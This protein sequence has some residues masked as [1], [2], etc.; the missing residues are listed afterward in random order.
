M[1]SPPSGTFHL[2]TKLTKVM[3][4]LQKHNKEGPLRKDM[5]RSQKPKK[6]RMSASALG[7]KMFQAIREGDVDALKEL[8]EEQPA[9]LND[10]KTEEGDFALHVATRL[11]NT[12]IVE[13]LMEHGASANIQ[14]DGGQTP[15]HIAVSNED[16]AMVNF[17]ISRSA[18][19]DIADSELLTATDLASRLE[20]TEISEK[21]RERV[22][23]PITPNTP[24]TPRQ[25]RALSNVYDSVLLAITTGN[26][27][28]LKEFLDDGYLDE[29]LL[30]TKSENG[31]TPLHIAIK[32][33]SVEICKILVQGGAKTE[34]KAVRDGSTLLHQ[35]CM[36]GQLDAS[37]A[38]IKKGVLVHMPNKSGSLCIHEAAKKGHLGLVRMLIER[39]VPVNFQNKRKY[40]PLHLAALSKKHQVVQLLIGHGAEVTAIGGLAKETPLH[41]AAKVKGGEKVVDVLIKSG[42]DPDT[43]KDNGERALHLAARCGNLEVVNILLRENTEVARR[44]K[45]GDTPLHF[46]CQNGHF[47]IVE[48]L[49]KQLFKDKT[50]LL[51]RLIV[52]I[53][54]NLGV[55]ALHSVAGIPQGTAGTE[56]LVNTV[57]ILLNHGADL[58][59]STYQK[60]ETP[61]HWCARSGNYQM[62]E[63]IF[64]FPKV[65]EYI[66]L[67]IINKTTA[68]GASPLMIASQ[69]GMLEVVQALLRFHARV[70]VFDEAG[71]TALHYA[72]SRGHVEVARE[73]LNS[74][75]YVNG[76]TKPNVRYSS[77]KTRKDN[78]E[79]LPIGTTPL[80]MAAEMG[81]PEF[82]RVLITKYNAIT[83]PLT[84]DKKSPLHL[85][86]E[87]GRLEVCKVLLDL[88]ADA[89]VADSKDMIP[90]HYAA[91]NDREEV[92][93]L[94]FNLR[95]DTMT[96]VNA[97]GL[98]ALHIASSNGS[99]QVVR[100]LVKLD[101]AKC[102]SDKGVLCKPLLLAARGGHKDIVEFL[103]Q[104]GASPTEEDTEGNSVLHLA[105]KFGQVKVIDM[106][107]GKTPLNRTSVKNGMTAIHVA[108]LY[109]Q[110][111][112]VQEFLTRAPYS[113]TL[114]SER[115]VLADGEDEDDDYGFTSLHL[116]AQNGDNTLVRAIT[117]H[118]GVRVDSVTVK[119][120]RTALHIASMEGHIEVASTLISKASVL[121]QL[122]DNDGRTSLHLA[123]ANG[124]RE[125]LTILI[126]QG[127]DIDAQD[128]MGNTALHIASEA[129]Y[130][131][132]V[133]LL[134][135]YGASPL[136]ENKTED[137][138][139]CLAAR[140]R[141]I[142]VLD[143][144]LSQR[145]N[146]E[147]L[148]SNKKFLLDL[149]ICSRSSN[150]KSLMTFTL[151]AP[152]P[153]HISSFLSRHYRI[154]TT[155]N[156]EHANEL[157]LA[158]GFCETVAKDLISISCAEDS[159]AVLNSID[160]KNVAFLDFL[161][162]CEL[163]QCVSH[164]LVQQYVTQIWFGDLRWE[165]WKFMVLFL[166]AFF[167]PP[168]WV[169]LSLPFKN[170]HRQIPIIK[171]ICR[172]ISHLYL[173]LLLC[174]TVVVPWNHDGSDL[175]PHW[176]EYLLFMWI[177]GMLL[178]EISSERERSG[179]GWVP[180]L[181][182]FLV[183]FGELLRMIAIG[184]GG[185]KRIGIVFVRNQFLGTALMLSGLQLLQ[186][187]SIHRLFGPWG[188]IIGHLVVD[189]LRFLLILTIFFSSFALQLAAVFKPLELKAANDTDP[190][191]ISAK[192]SVSFLKIVELL[193]FGIFGL[194]NQ[195]DFASDDIRAKDMSKVVFGLY[196]VL[197]IIVLINLLIA[198]M[199]DT[200]QRLQVESDVAWKFGRARLIRNM[201][202]ET[203]NPTPI[204]LFSKLV[205]VFKMLYRSRCRCRVQ[206]IAVQQEDNNG[207][208]DIVR[209]RRVSIMRGD[210]SM[211]EDAYQEWS[212]IQSVVDWDNVVE[213]FLD[214]RGEKS[215]R[216]KH[217]RTRRDRRRTT[218]LTKS[219]DLSGAA[220]EARV[221]KTH[222]RVV[223][224]T[225]VRMN[226]LNSLKL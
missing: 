184:Y 208:G 158:S 89:N 186:F 209:R 215:V 107:W 16:E 140:E 157:E 131:A 11:K 45:S 146:H 55:T 13:L 203:S 135:E 70:D 94:F 211:D 194:T 172:L 162:E 27:E 34:T 10:V 214:S 90:V 21:L 220:D 212:L 197:V 36:A 83:D 97:E 15:L 96:Q 168:I 112:V 123:S 105:A 2:Q 6:K 5:K 9:Q 193:F 18:K 147:R 77:D 20:N 114:V 104:N 56:D 216:R 49:I 67:S 30:E 28:D 75:A 52:N 165:D 106:L 42:A 68:S 23:T 29:D 219:T 142:E 33:K 1:R 151:S 40:T 51:A 63:K 38:L 205:H 155:K 130:N 132:V 3:K 200:Y 164:P 152:A 183:L 48:A 150:Y 177:I 7:A 58:T 61:L 143:F 14:N 8:L 124:H 84:V 138:P 221:D 141:H 182:V 191:V 31:E 179:L 192:T 82:V 99:I 173:I 174:L 50:Y 72:A 60:G 129:G 195:K 145:L 81:H 19:T 213:K 65:P 222:N 41:M 139:I 204:N 178:T 79:D 136:I 62:I 119:A 4:S 26:V 144:L 223:D 160:G 210:E 180:T 88:R 156:K 100:K 66:R 108:A 206:E 47:Q 110:T 111:E 137:L 17:L 201:E 12:E 109:G 122:M 71:G 190:S 171:F 95:P 92:V 159:G 91:L 103:L 218:Q 80:H 69:Y 126:G 202:R 154:E 76:R 226:V 59:F 78:K 32:L 217:R 115:P 153:V 120:G 127:A 46:A 113:A 102:S 117:N 57:E 167:F 25:R 207:L 39:G 170:R 87:Y 54:N 189:V 35:T 64:T 175:L 116:A 163:K 37:N 24:N 98:N 161:I 185:E 43:A 169:Y 188:V 101:F 121:L 133:K 134:V 199:S 53:P 181:V 196:N 149:V 93:E 198:M 225:A 176:F 44:S 125:L 74:K 118:P 128:N 187:L 224:D 166:V 148:I 22:P 73:L 85:A 86:A